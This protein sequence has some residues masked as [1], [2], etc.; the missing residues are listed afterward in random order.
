M[1]S[2]R[3]PKAAPRRRPAQ[4][5]EPPVV[6]F[7]SLGC[8]KNLVDSEVML[9]RIAESGAIITPDESAADTIVVNTCGFLEAARAEALEVLTDLA[10]RKKDGS[11]RRLVVVGCLVQR[12]GEMLLEAVPEIDALVGVHRRDDVARA[13]WG[14][15]PRGR[16]RRTQGH[17]LHLGD[18]H[19]QPW[20]DQG[21]LRLTPAHYAYIRLSEGCNQKCTFCTIPSIRG[22]LHSKT[23]AEIITECQELIADGAQELILIGQDTTSYGRDR[24]DDAG[25]PGL[26]RQLDAACTGARWLRLMYVYPSVF[27]DEAIAALAECAR[28]VKYVDLPLQHINDRIL[29]RMGRRVTRE[30]TEALLEKLRRQIPG[31]AIRTTMIVGF[32]GETD[33]EFDELLA[34]V[35][36]FGFEAAAAFRYSPEPGTPAIRLPGQIP[37]EI[38]QERHERFM[39]T[40][41]EVALAA[42]RARIGQE[43]D[44]LVDGADEAGQLVAR[45]AGQAPEVDAVCLLPAEAA[46][47]GEFVPVRCVEAADYDLVVQP[48]RRRLPVKH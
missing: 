48:R 40:Q 20:N 6:G 41:H 36:D 42:A 18:Y 1:S 28:V 10:T 37:D 45:H 23:P 24:G 12:D 8:A 19:P 25:L 4:P 43:F 15:A 9:G 16:S 27:D 46:S 17:E 47:V 21:R 30:Q 2:N 35:R 32:P 13:V 22:P 7:V 34:F 14:T 44:V 26:L 11:L 31:V 29:R 3:K 38:R 33:A 5:A 39:L